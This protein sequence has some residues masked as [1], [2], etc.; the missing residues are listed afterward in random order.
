[1]Q[2]LKSTVAKQEA[3]IER[4]QKEFQS[5]IVQQRIGTVANPTTAPALTLT[6]GDSSNNTKTAVFDVS[7]ITTGTQRTINVPN[8]NSTLSLDY[9]ES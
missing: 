3:T 9:R 2:E 8:A 1:M 5:T 4:Q 7:H 6:I